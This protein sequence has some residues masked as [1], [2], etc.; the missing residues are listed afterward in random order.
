MAN[1]GETSLKPYNYSVA[2]KGV[3]VLNG[4]TQYELTGDFKKTNNERKTCK[5]QLHVKLVFDFLPCVLLCASVRLLMRF[6]NLSTGKTPIY[7]NRCSRNQ[8]RLVVFMNE[9]I[10]LMELFEEKV[11]Q[12]SGP[13]L[14]SFYI[15][16]LHINFAFQPLATS[17][18]QCHN[19]SQSGT[20]ALQW[21]WHND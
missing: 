15:H 20:I 5:Y 13:G 7:H 6:E 4:C 8:F 21:H 2:A 12:G 14:L 3:I 17:P 1:W 16:I 19:L 9:F 11:M 10:F 18:W